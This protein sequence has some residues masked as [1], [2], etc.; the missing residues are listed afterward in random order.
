LE[1]AGCQQDSGCLAHHEA[2][3]I[4]RHA[5]SVWVQRHPVCGYFSPLAHGPLDP[6]SEG[7]VL[8][9]GLELRYPILED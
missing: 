4:T 1:E 7:C 8:M 6:D 2:N 9:S 3:I 5:R